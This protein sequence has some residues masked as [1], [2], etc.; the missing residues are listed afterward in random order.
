MVN[1]HPP[2]YPPWPLGPRASRAPRAPLSPPS[3]FAR[4]SPGVAR[5][6]PPTPVQQG[7]GCLTPQWRLSTT[8]GLLCRRALS[9]TRTGFWKLPC[10]PG[11]AGLWSPLPSQVLH[12]NRP[13]V[14]PTL[15]T[16][17]HAWSPEQ[18]FWPVPVFL[19]YLVII[20]A[21]RNPTGTLQQ[22]LSSKRR[23]SCFLVSSSPSGKQYA[24]YDVR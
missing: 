18:W 6:A 24:W 23:T 17:P 22:D 5:A 4:S 21:V 12:W 15:P 7:L 19:L 16:Q 14:V 1:H 3:C 10:L 8:W 11:V 13:G 20:H 9:R 2:K